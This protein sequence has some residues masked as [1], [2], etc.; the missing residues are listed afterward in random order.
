MVN[1]AGLRLQLLSNF[2]DPSPLTT[3]EKE[4]MLTRLQFNLISET[5]SATL[6][7]AEQTSFMALSPIEKVGVIKAMCEEKYFGFDATIFPEY[8]VAIAVADNKSGAS[9]QHDIDAIAAAVGFPLVITPIVWHRPKP[10]KLFPEL[11][12]KWPEEAAKMGAI[13]AKIG[14]AWAGNEPSYQNATHEALGLGGWLDFLLGR[15]IPATDPTMALFI[16]GASVALRGARGEWFDD[17][18]QQFLRLPIGVDGKSVEEIDWDAEYENR[19]RRRAVTRDT[20][21][22]RRQKAIK[23]KKEHREAAFLILTTATGYATLVDNL[24]LSTFEKMRDILTSNPV[25][26]DTAGGKTWIASVVMKQFEIVYPI[27]NPE[28]LE[29]VE[30]FVLTQVNKRL[31]NWFRETED[32]TLKIRRAPKIN[33]PTGLDRPTRSLHKHLD[34]LITKHT[35]E[36]VGTALLTIAGKQFTWAQVISLVDAA[37]SK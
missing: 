25:G 16:M 18:E 22:K 26:V 20:A 27:A 13:A 1:S 36:K 10:P 6:S 14:F 12:V 33:R 2:I 7:A 32:G 17:E 37:S 34:K 29:F 4:I 15:Q 23:E 19:L 9:V 24:S 30:Q 28:M 11:T 5:I 21:A 3:N 31:P 8:V 35:V